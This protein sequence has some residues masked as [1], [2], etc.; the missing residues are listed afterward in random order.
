VVFKGAR[1]TAVLT[2]Q[3]APPLT[4]LWVPEG[5]LGR[6]VAGAARLTLR[7]DHVRWTRFGERARTCFPR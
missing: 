5:E 2:E 4:L 3:G 6:Y 1:G 7:E